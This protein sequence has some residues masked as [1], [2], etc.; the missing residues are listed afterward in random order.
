[1]DRQRPLEA[2]LNGCDNGTLA[3]ATCP[4]IL[5]ERGFLIRESHLAILPTEAGD[6]FCN[7]DSMGGIFCTRF[8]LWISLA[9]LGCILRHFSLWHVSPSNT[10]PIY[11]LCCLLSPSLDYRLAEGTDFVLFT[12]VPLA[13]ARCLAQA[14]MWYLLHDGLWFPTL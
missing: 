10:H 6:E 9:S 11:Y 8:A 7:Q 5:D 3:Q 13:L 12:A 1:M 4:V 2:V 14:S